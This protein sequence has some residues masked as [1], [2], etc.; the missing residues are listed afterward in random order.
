MSTASQVGWQKVTEQEGAVPVWMAEVW[1]VS[2]K[3][4]IAAHA[5]TAP[6]AI[7]KAALL[8]LRGDLTGRYSASP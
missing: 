1:P 8:A 3:L 2:S 5:P 6:E 7:C 4:P